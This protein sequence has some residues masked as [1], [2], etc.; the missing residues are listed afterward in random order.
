MLS[1]FNRQRLDAESIR[2]AL[3]A[4]SGALD[5]N[6]ASAPHPF[7]KEPTWDFTQHK[8]FNA[9][10][11]TQRRSVYLM[12]QRIQRQPYLTVFDGPD[13]NASTAER[14]AT[15]TPIQALFMM[16]SEFLHEQ[17]D[18]LAGRLADAAPDTRQQVDRAHEIALGASAGSR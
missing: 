13:P 5:C 1:H 6:S 10:Y 4:V 12:T 14:T 11:D 15:T 16:N 3:L 8:P 17:A 2:D 9:V 18:R 7:P